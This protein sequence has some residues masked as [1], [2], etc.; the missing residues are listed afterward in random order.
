MRW[1]LVLCLALVAEASVADKLSLNQISRY[2]NGFKTGTGEFTQINEDGTLSTGTIFIKRPGRMRFEY[3]PPEATLVV[4]GQG[5]VVIEDKKSNSNPES[6]PLNR[7]PLSLI[8]ANRVD[9]GRAEMVTGHRFDGT[10]TIVTAQDPENPETGNIQLYFTSDPV[11]LRQWV[12]TDA[13]GITTAIILGALQ[14]GGRLRDSLFDTSVI[15][16]VER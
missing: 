15:G 14:K 16:A 3:N 7:T 11:E 13:N 10:A 8:L 2:L 5:S 9:L 6:Y 1:I 4:V 12:I